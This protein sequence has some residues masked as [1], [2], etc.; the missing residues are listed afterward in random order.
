MT[1]TLAVIETA[2]RHQIEA[3]RGLCGDNWPQHLDTTNIQPGQLYAELIDHVSLEQISDQL[4]ELALGA[5]RRR[6]LTIAKLVIKYEVTSDQFSMVGKHILL[7]CAKL[8]LQS[9]PQRPSS[10][11]E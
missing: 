6:Q 11:G 2:S 1:Q 3:V 7:M 10:E 5:A 9:L 4:S 8:L